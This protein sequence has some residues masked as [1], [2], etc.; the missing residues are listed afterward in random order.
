MPVPEFSSLIVSFY[1]GKRISFFF[2]FFCLHLPD[3]DLNCILYRLS[4]GQADIQSEVIQ[5]GGS[6]LF[7]LCDLYVWL[8]KKKRL[9]PPFVKKNLITWPFFLNQRLFSGPSIQL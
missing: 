6:E 4:K 2:F 5:T 9:S 8:K 1:F 3:C 7:Y